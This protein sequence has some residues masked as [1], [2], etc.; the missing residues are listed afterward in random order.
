MKGANRKARVA[1]VEMKN[2]VDDAY[3]PIT[4]GKG[5]PLAI[6]GTHNQPPGKRN[7]F[8]VSHKEDERGL[9]DGG[10]EVPWG[11]GKSHYIRR[12]H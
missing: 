5:L 4:R 6:N 9:R 2:T 1:A 8:E 12:N 11:R 3:G 10:E 7:G